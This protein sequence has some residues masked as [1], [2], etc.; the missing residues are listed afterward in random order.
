M[1]QA[2]PET[3]K[4][5]RSAEKERVVSVPQSKQQKS[6]F[7][8]TNFYLFRTE[9]IEILFA[10]PEV[11]GPRTPH[12]SFCAVQLRTLCTACSLATLWLSATSFPES[13][14]P[15]FWGSMFFPHA[16]ILRNGSGKN[17]NS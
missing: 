14:L 13:K 2:S 17:K 11:I 6:F 8:V 1:A 3:R 15:G 5:A 10:E 4:H 16:L 9:N 7:S 12:I